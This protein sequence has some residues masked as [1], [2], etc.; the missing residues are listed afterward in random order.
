MKIMITGAAGFIGSHLTD[1]CLAEGHEVIAVDNLSMGRKE[2]L[3]QHADNER[4]RFFEIDVL[5]YPALKKCVESTGGLDRIVHLAAFKIPRYGNAI[6]TLTINNLGTVNTLQLAREYNCKIIVASTSDVYGKNPNL[7]FHEESDLVIGPSSRSRWSYAISKLYDE[8]L[9]LAS[10]EA[11]G[12]PVVLLR[13]FGSYGPRQH[14][15]W[16]G[17]PQSVFIEKILKGETSPIHGDGQQTRS[18]TFI[19]DTVAGIYQAIVRDTANGQIF[20]IGATREITIENLVRLIHKLIPDAPPLNI[21]FIPYEQL[22][23]GYEDVMRRVPDD[24]KCFEILGVRAKV[25][26]EDGLLET[27]AWQRREQGL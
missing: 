17:G 7:P 14:L 21:E 1:L 4:F 24:S 10:M 26:M 9:C 25:T 2:N 13:F 11:Y 15:S 18:F 8:H 16:W 12:F 19:S 3:A 22:S 20:N 5:D 23:K 27:I 6:D